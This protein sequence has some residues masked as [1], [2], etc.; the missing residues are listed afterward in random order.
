V[1]HREHF[2]A[3][4]EGK[5][6]AA[7]PFFPDISD[8]YVGI[9]TPP[10]Q[11]RKR[12]CA[13][14]IPDDDPF[15]DEP[16]EQ[17]EELRGLTLLDIYKKYD[18]GYP[19]HIGDW[20]GIEYEGDVTSK[21]THE[22]NKR[23]TTLTTPRGALRYV[24]K[25]AVDG[26]WAPIEH[27]C[28]E[29]RDLEIIKLVLEATRYVPRYE[30]VARVME[31]MGSQ[32]LGDLI[33][34][35]SPFGKLVHWYLGFENV[36][37]ALVDDAGYLED[38]MQLQEAKDL[39]LIELAAGAPERLVI[40]SDHADENLIAPPHYEEY[41]V[42]YYSKACKI[43]H[44]GGKF[45]STHLDGNFRGFFPVLGDTGLDLLDGVTP[46]PMFNFEVEELAAALP[47]GMYSYCGV[48][49]TL[50]CQRLPKEE[51][52]AFADRIMHALKGRGILNVGDILPPNGDIEQVIALGR[53]VA[54]RNAQER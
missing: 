51:I 15:H 2:F 35:R 49:S 33:I 20:Y 31:Q 10:G 46:A 45:V 7:M 32:G 13:K 21:V 22:P 44:N 43:L 17:P 53:Y 5:R 8:W 50:F 42:P 29:L 40:I 30:N 52:F 24:E 54:E 38:F 3:V 12:G 25:M 14:F 47:K 11:A 28:K 1:T 37:Y 19:V 41:C 4:L 34:W 6:P 27:Y 9:R 26:T 23:I 16:C 36:I 48:P 18:W 39:E